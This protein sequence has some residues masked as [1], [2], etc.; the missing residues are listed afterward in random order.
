MMK[1]MN[2][3]FFAYDDGED[4]D[5][6]DDDDDYDE[7]MMMMMMMSPVGGLSSLFHWLILSKFSLPPYLFPEHCFMLTM[8]FT[9][10][11]SISS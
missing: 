5:N 9:I 2:D 3:F 10:L 1:S 6:D 4:D 8:L 7:A 11:I